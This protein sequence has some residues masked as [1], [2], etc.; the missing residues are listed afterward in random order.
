MVDFE[1]LPPRLSRR[2]ASDYLKAK[3]GIIR[4]PSTLAKYVVTGGG[5]EFRRVGARGVAYDVP[6]LD[7]YA[8]ELIGESAEPGTAQLTPEGGPRHQPGH[9]QTVFGGREDPESTT[10]R[11]QWS[12][13]GFTGS[14]Q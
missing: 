9:V 12:S 11:P 5:P 4:A 2:E 1:N 14:I 13:S 6:E 10:S 8:E 3:H 7:R